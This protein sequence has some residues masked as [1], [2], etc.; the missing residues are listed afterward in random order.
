MTDPSGPSSPPAPAAPSSAPPSPAAA[1][2]PIA[3]LDTP[4]RWVA[5]GAAVAIVVLVLGVVL[6]AWEVGGYALV[7][8][9]AAIVAL[10]LALIVSPASGGA[11]PVPA[12]D[13]ALLAGVLMSVLA[14]L[15]LLEVLFDLD[16]ID[17]ERGGVLGLLLTIVLA[18]ASLAVFV[19]AWMAHRERDVVGAATRRSDRGTRIA[20]A[21]LG[22]DVLAWLIMLTISVYSLG[23]TASFGIAASVLAVLVLVLGADPEHPWRLPIPAAWIAI[24]L[25]LVSAFM[26]LD[27]Y[28]Q[29]SRNSSRLDAIDSVLFLLHVVAVLVILAG[30]VVAAYDRRRHLA[31]PSSS[32]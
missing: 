21:G 30:A 11:W 10:I 3:K 25:S 16:Q 23:A 31:A 6:G 28:G 27:M 5:G 22:L 32:A 9:V 20:L 14:V 24:G 19:G 13:I 15:N 17:D 2:N 1:A 26:L 8:L 7:V 29:W 18:A 12:R 4:G